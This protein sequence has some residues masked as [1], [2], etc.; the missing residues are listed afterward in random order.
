MD[1]PVLVGWTASRFRRLIVSRRRPPRTATENFDVSLSNTIPQ[2]APPGGHTGPEWAMPEV[3]DHFA[4]QMDAGFSAL[5]FDAALETDFLAA[6]QQ[7]SAQRIRV[8]N[9]SVLVASIAY[10][11]ADPG[12]TVETL[13]F[14]SDWVVGVLL[15]AVLLS[16]V[17]LTAIGSL[18][19]ARRQQLECGLVL[20]F[21]V[22]VA[23]VIALGRQGADNFPY[24]PMLLMAVY[25]YFLTGLLFW[26][27]ATCGMLV[28]GV[29]VFLIEVQ[30]PVG[31]AFY[32]A[33]YLLVMN[34]LGCLGL[35]FV[36]RR[37]RQAY[38]LE[39]QLRLQAVSDGLTKLMNRGAFRNHLDAVWQM[40]SRDRKRIGLLLLDLDHFKDV[41]D[42]CGHLAGD[43]ALIQVGAAL[44][45][46]IKRPLDAAGRYGG[47]E[48]IAVWFDVHPD[49]FAAVPERIRAEL[50]GVSLKGE[51]RHAGQCPI[52]VSIGAVSLLPDVSSTPKRAMSAADEMLYEVKEAGRN[53]FRVQE[54]DKDPDSE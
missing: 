6:H 17:A 44:R 48:F 25:I 21:G 54:L 43:E 33:Y 24:E 29:Y 34:L 3:E 11:L 18:R 45:A 15:A 5:R 8:A 7:L 1:S 38:L 20:G 13:R 4:R 23:A 2:A 9:L 36:E 46:Q 32:E 16:G 22:G 30:V 19:P 37:H 28:W 10:L 42:R 35:Y 27:A 53:G 41:N 14:A 31:R 26:Q 49:W 12:R 52:T 47:D 50:K 40:A 51:G 39:N